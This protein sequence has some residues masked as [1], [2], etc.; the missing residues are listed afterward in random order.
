[1]RFQSIQNRKK[2]VGQTLTEYLLLLCLIVVASIPIVGIL[3]NVLRDQLKVA[4]ERLGGETAESN[5]KNYLKPAS[6]K[7]VRG[8]D[9]FWKQ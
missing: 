9:D 6:G 3:S 5:S 8:L 1:M 2:R 4:S 7:V